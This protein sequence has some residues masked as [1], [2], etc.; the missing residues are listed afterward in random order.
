MLE[1]NA[2]KTEKITEKFYK[3]L[4]KVNRNQTINYLFVIIFL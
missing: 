3:T 2:N 4:K 1:E